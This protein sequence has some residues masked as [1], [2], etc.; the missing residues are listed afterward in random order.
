MKSNTLFSVLL[1]LAAAR[2]L[3]TSPSPGPDTTALTPRVSASTNALLALVAS[4]FP[5]NLAVQDVGDVIT[6]AETGFAAVLGYPTPE[7][8]LERGTTEPGDVGAL[9][10]PPFFDSVRAQ[11]PGGKTLAVQGVDDYAADIPGFLEGG[12]AAGSQRM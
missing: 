12:E 8:A 11:L 4:L 9:V 3:P 7:N 1:S 10:G 5:V 2:A 6:D